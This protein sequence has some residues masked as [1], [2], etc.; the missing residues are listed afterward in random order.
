V[1]YI[2]LG[3]YTLL[4]L[5]VPLQCNIV[6]Y[7]TFSSTTLNQSTVY[8]RLCDLTTDLACTIGAICENALFVRPGILSANPLAESQIQAGAFHCLRK[9]QVIK[10]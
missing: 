6:P 4:G 10:A 3:I 1:K 2:K 9:T 8:R 7:S 5:E